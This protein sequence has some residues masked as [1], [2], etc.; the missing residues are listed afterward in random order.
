MRGA[1]PLLPNTPT[2]C[3]VQ[4]KHKDKFVFIITFHLYLLLSKRVI[5]FYDV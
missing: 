5:L 2:W 1:E 4:L 3:G